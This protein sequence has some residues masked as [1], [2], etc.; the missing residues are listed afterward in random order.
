M[1]KAGTI[2]QREDPSASLERSCPLSAFDYSALP[3]SANQAVRRFGTMT[4]N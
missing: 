1:I 4:A 3:G 2:L